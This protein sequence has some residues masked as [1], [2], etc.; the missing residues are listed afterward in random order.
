MVVG[1]AL[2]DHIASAE[3]AE[4]AVDGVLSLCAAL[5]EGVRKA[6]VS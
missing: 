2:I 5:S 6:R 4:Q 1:S 3:S